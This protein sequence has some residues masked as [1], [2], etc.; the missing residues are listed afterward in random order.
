LIDTVQPA[1][2]GTSKDFSAK[3]E[4]ATEDPDA[5]LVEL[6]RSLLFGQGNSFVLR[7]DKSEV[8]ELPPKT[9]HPLYAEMTDWEVQTHQ[10]LLRSVGGGSP[11]KILHKMVALYQHPSLLKEEGGSLD[12]A[13]LL[14]DSSK[15]RAVIE[16][17][18]ESARF[19]IGARKW[20]FL[21][22]ESRCSRFSL[23]SS[24]RSVVSR[25]TS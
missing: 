16:K 17:L 9:Y 8:L 7:R 25:R 12:A 5:R 4:R 23:P 22:T 21:L 14:R 10:E 3:Y 1:L 11:I 24:H 2:L 6:K 13:K 18:R 15:L 20:S 19:V